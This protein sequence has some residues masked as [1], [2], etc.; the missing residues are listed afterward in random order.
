MDIA[1]A[2]RRALRGRA[3]D[4]ERLLWRL[5]RMRQ[6]LG[7]D[8]T[9]EIPHPCLSRVV[10]LSGKSRKDLAM[11]RSSA[12]KIDQLLERVVALEGEVRGIQETITPREKL[13]RVVERIRQKTKH[14]PPHELD[15][16]IHGALRETRGGKGCR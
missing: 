12:I 4:A 14:I 15:K 8:R 3:T 11:P 2:R 9:G 16:A 1:L 10:N 5:L 13:R 7:L 6:F